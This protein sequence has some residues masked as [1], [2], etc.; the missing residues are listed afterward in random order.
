MRPLESHFHSAGASATAGP[1]VATMG[2]R[3]KPMV[4][5]RFYRSASS[6]HP[7]TA[8]TPATDARE[9]RRLSASP[10]DVE[11]P[12]P[13]VSPV[14]MVGRWNLLGMALGMYEERIY[15]W[16]R[17]VFSLPAAPTDPEPRTRS[18]SA[19]RPSTPA[20]AAST[21]PCTSASTAG[22]RPSRCARARPRPSSRRRRAAPATPT[23]PTPASSAASLTRCATSCAA[24]RPSTFRPVPPRPTGSRGGEGGKEREA[25]EVDYAA[26]RAVAEQERKRGPVPTGRGG[27]Q[28]GGWKKA[29]RLASQASPPHAHT[30]VERSPRPGFGSGA[31]QRAAHAPR[32][33]SPRGRW[34]RGQ[35]S[36]TQLG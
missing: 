19:R 36:S 3:N 16:V 9:S 32:Y 23:P 6:P 8:T 29:D 5:H 34:G 28:R 27:E 15:E 10:S 21:A 33:N 7:T 4:E 22:T 13:V 2:S 20:S 26:D 18:S 14:A 35:S 30:Q 25:R 12:N 17:I 31:D 24:P 1:R 11:R